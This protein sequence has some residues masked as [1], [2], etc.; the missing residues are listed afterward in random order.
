MPH[1]IFKS[2]HSFVLLILFVIC[3]IPKQSLAALPLKVAIDAGHGGKDRG[4]VRNQMAEADLV[5][6]LAKKLSKKLQDSGQFQVTLTRSEDRSLTLK[7]RR[8]KTQAAKADLIISLHANASPDLKANGVEFYFE[9]SL[10]TDPVSAF[11]ANHSLEAEVEEALKEE[12]RAP[13]VSEIEDILRDLKK[14]DQV[15]LSQEASRQLRHAWKSADEQRRRPV[16]QA[17]FYL[18][19]R[20]NRPAVLVEVGFLSHPEEQLRL[21]SVAYQDEIVNNLFNGI[22]KY[23]ELIDKRNSPT[24]D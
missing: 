21:K 3:L 7:E 4:A 8:L 16:R 6:G 1:S 14:M 11:L 18:V 13:Q 9:N 10:P 12:Q 20:T 17:P 22:T 2:V 15:I 19:S 23:K 5:L 24:L